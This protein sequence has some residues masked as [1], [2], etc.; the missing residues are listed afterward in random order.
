[1][2]SLLSM[3][4]LS[5]WYLFPQVSS[6]SLTYHPVDTPF[7]PLFETRALF[8]INS[9]TLQITLVTALNSPIIHVIF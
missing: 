8:S 7:Q 1:L 3:A 4:F 9:R 5:L 2:L 6:P